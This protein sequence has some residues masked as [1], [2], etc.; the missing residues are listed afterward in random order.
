MRTIVFATIASLLLLSACEETPVGEAVFENVIPVP[1]FIGHAVDEE[2]FELNASTRIQY[3]AGDAIMQHTATLLAEY[4]EQQLGL[5]LTVEEAEATE[6]EAVNSIFLQINK[7]GNNGQEGYAFQIS[8]DRILIQSAGEAGIFYGVQTLRKALPVMQSASGPVQA[9]ERVNI[10]CGAV[11]GN[12]RFGYRGAHLDVSRHFFPIDSVKSYIDMLA[13]HN[14]N[15]FHWHL[16]DDQGWRIEIKKYPELTRQGSLRHGTMVNRDWSSNDGIDYGGYYTQE[17]AREVVRYAAERFITVIPEIDM[18][19]HMQAA[20]KGYP[21]LGCTGG[22]YEVWTV[23]GVSDD[24]LCAGNDK[25]YTFCCDVLDEIM[26]IFPAKYIHIG[27]DE[28]PKTR[29][30]ECKKCQARI[31]KLKLTGDEHFSAEQQLQSYFTQRIDSYLTTHGRN[32]IGWD[33]I[34][35]G[36]ISDNATIM[37]WRGTEG[38]RQA[39]LQNH[40]AIMTPIDC[41]YLNFY[42]TSDTVGEPMAFDGYC[43]LT[44]L[45]NYD[46]VPE[47]LSPEQRNCIIGVQGNLW[48][49]Y[50]SEWNVAQYMFLPRAAALAEVQW[51]KP[52]EKNYEE[53]LQRLDHLKELYNLYGWNFCNKIE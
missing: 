45:Y 47:G 48:S 32:A 44:R 28:C 40:R 26:E 19:G 20:L 23:W 4:I 7:N 33:E 14:M 29:W 10:P 12:P 8:H 9:P 49:E 42:Q 3:T 22:P 5:K 39:A 30:Q 11:V 15:T 24:V 17:E 18:P 46:P 35:E 52:Q 1:E 21:E 38:G 6:K 34:L 2:D 53:F 43:P 37:S 36:G 13:L 50:F 51:L 25:V 41:L 16:T 31:K 27:G